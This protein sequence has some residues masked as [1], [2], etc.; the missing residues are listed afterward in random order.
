M[1]DV[2]TLRV[3]QVNQCEANADGAYVLYWMI[4][5]RRLGW[6]FALQRAVGW[7]ARLGK[8]LFVLEPLRANYPWASR[9]LHRF[10]LDGMA[11][12]DAALRGTGVGYYPYVEP[13]AGAGKGLLRALADRACVVVTDEY[14]AFFLPRMVEAAALQLPMKLEAVD[15]NGLLPMRAAEQAYPTAYAFRRLL[16]KALPAHLAPFPLAKPL[17]AT[18]LPPL[19]QLPADVGARWPRATREL[20]EDGEALANLPIDQEVGPVSDCPG[21]TR[22]AEARLRAFLD[23]RLAR[24]GERGDLTDENTSGLSPY[25]HFGHIAPHQIFAALAER[26]G[27]DAKRLSSESKGKRSGWWGLPA[28]AESFLDELV[29]WRELGFNFCHHRA[30][31][32]QY[33]SLPDWARATLA[34]HADDPRDPL[35][36]RDEFEAAQTHD[37]LW[38]AAQTQLAREGRIH[39]YLRMLWGKKIVEWSA[40]PRE[41][42]AIMLELNNKYALDGRDPNSYSGIFWCL[43]RFDRPWRER[44]VFGKVRYMSSKNTARKF[45]VEAYLARFAPGSA[46]ECP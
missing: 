18:S 25:L 35:Y 34:A 33:E 22:A 26:E 37:P 39:G 29:T 41:A 42:L 3:R 31:Y 20:L 15:S 14:P 30:D 11:E 2:P 16:Q 5:Q 7:A 17:A 8:P 38:N 28:R 24:Y 6:N 4:A 43:G 44:P 27:W 23:T 21:G 36:A 12:H 9:R 46:A 19:G 10:V 45:E 40:S 32:A 13:E 1:K